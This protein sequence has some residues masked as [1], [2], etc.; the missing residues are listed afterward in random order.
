MG[1]TALAEVTILCMHFCFKQGC[2]YIRPDQS[3]LYFI[4]MLIY[5]CIDYTLSELNNFILCLVHATTD[6]RTVF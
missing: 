4:C 3:V 5:F 6:Q 1:T 2:P